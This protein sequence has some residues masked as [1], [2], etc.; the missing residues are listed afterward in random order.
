M[1]KEETIKKITEILSNAEDYGDCTECGI[2]LWE[3]D[4]ESGLCEDCRDELV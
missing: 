4:V 2:P 3:E 1:N